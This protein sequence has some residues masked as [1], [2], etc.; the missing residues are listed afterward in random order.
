MNGS[1]F[2]RLVRHFTAEPSRRDLLRTA[3]AATVAGLGGGS[4]LGN[5]AE[6]TQSCKKK[7]KRKNSKEARRKCKQ[8]CNKNVCLP[9]APEAPC[10]SSSE[11]C[12]EQTKYTCAVSHNS[13]LDSVCCGT[14]GAAC[15]TTFQ[16]CLGFNCESGTCV[17][18][19]S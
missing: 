13:G 12:P 10:Q 9:K 11:C 19:G 8:K 17:P 3:F 6:A 5:A 16:C 14:Q 4:L 15:S 1:S 18:M 2:D 7:C